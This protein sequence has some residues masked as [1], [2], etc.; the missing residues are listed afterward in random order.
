MKLARLKSIVVLSN[1]S[2]VF[3]YNPKIKIKQITY[4]EKDQTAFYNVKDKNISSR[5]SLNNKKNYKL[6]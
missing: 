6:Y 1:G 4:S 5:S 3:N 2:V